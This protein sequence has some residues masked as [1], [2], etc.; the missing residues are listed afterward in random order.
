[1]TRSSIQARLENL[2]LVAELGRQRELAERARAEAEAANRDKS[3][4]LAAASH[5]LR[6]PVHAL[7]LF[8]AAARH[9]TTEE[10]RRAIL[11]R[12]D[13]SLAA[14]TALFDSLLEISR[15]DAR[16]LEARVRHVD[17]APMLTRL[18]GE[19][20]G[21]ARAKGLELRVR[22][23]PLRVRTDPLLLE[24]ILRNLLANAVRYTERGGALLAARRRGSLVRVGVWDTGIGI[25]EEQ[26]RRVFEPFFQV[27]NPERDR[28]RGVGLGLAIVERV[29]ALLHHPLHVTS[30]VGRGSCFA[31]DLPVSLGTDIE[32]EGTELPFDARERALLGAVIVVIDDEPTNRAALALVLEQFGCAVVTAG[33]GS[34]AL[35]ALE[36][37]GTPPDALISDYRLRGAETGIGATEALRAVY[38]A[39]LPAVLVTGD[40]A[41]DRLL[42]A[43]ASGLEVL[44]KPVT[45]ETLERTLVRSLA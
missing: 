13:A 24:R 28:E 26:R 1:M 11:E 43:E 37:R 31:L 30:R 41:P 14:L 6:Q 4:F 29:A 21:L 39:E 18:H 2:E 36:A 15:L 32:R 25:A 33:S 5:D 40:T 42:E 3:R 17:L 20:S 45:A 7:G 12:I 19:Y 9:A 23:A 8:A 27:G 35:R 22:L 38:G 16:V 10:E 34:E 44:H